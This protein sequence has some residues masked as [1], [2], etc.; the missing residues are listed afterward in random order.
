MQRTGLLQ[1]WHV[2]QEELILEL[3][4]ETGGLTPRLMKLI[5]TLFGHVS[6]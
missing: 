5:H 6:R 4:K 2:V 3:G 1:R